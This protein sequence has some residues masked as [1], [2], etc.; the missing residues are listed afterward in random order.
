MPVPDR[1]VVD[2]TPW[3]TRVAFLASGE[4]VDL[5]VEAADRPSLPGGV[6][7]AR[8]LAVHPGL[9][10]ATVAIPGGEAFLSDRAVVEG[11]RLVVQIVR[12][13]AGGKRAVARA[14][15]ELVSGPVVLTPLAP[16][17]GLSSSIRGKARRAALRAALAE[18][19]ADAAAGLL[20]RS[21]GAGAEIER[22][23]A[24]ATALLGRWRR[25]LADARGSEP[26]C[27]LE[28][29]PPLLEAVLAHAPGVEPEIDDTGRAFEACGGADALDSALARRVVLP[30][31]G[32]LV[33]DAA[34][35]ATLIDV[36]LPAGGGR[37][38]FRRANETAGLAALRQIRLRGVRGIA[39][40][41]LPRMTDAAARARV[42]SLVAE[43]AAA[44]PVP[45]RVLGWSAAGFLEIVREGARR[46]LADD[47][48]EQP[49][50]PAPSPR[51]AAWAALAG[52]RREAARIARPRLC[53]APAVARWLE[54]DGAP[55]MQAE[56]VRL[57]HL[58]VRADPALSRETFRVE[59][60]D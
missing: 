36:N 40:V 27:W 1:I 58:T 33:V 38:G 18:C 10:A 54:A 17:I 29:P 3:A 53:V 55:I 42:L 57:G 50:E 13:A 2:R 21:A 5:W 44:D 49:G 24:D 25:I 6:A 43:A 15:V 37:E 46:P 23:V 52:L 56:R 30:G 32:E 31:G 26:P 39:L 8:V 16:G 35:A 41:D 20:V 45:T 12:D 59:S 51:A 11:E 19:A 48:L 28:P 9:A 47:L 7:L 60:E 22:L 4:V 14:G 34:E